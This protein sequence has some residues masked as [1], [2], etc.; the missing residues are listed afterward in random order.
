MLTA[1]PKLVEPDR[2]EGAVRVETTR[3]RRNSS[4]DATARDIDTAYSQSGQ[5]GSSDFHTSA[6]SPDQRIGLTG[7][8][9]VNKPQ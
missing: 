7:A 3:T 6:A 8:L 4:L 1:S 2:D 5:A 9:P